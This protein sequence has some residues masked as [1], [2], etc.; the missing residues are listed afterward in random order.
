MSHDASGEPVSPPSA[1]FSRWANRNVAWARIFVEELARAGLRE[2]CIAPGSRSGPLVLALDADPRIRTFVHLDERSAGYFALGIGKA[3]G[4]PAI[5]VTTSGTAAANLLPAVVEASQGEAPL[6]V[7]TADRPHR[8]RG[9]AANQTIDQVK[10]YGPYAR[11]FHDVAPPRLDEECLRYLRGLAGR[12]VAAARGPPA[13]PV[14]LNFPFDKPLEPT[15]VPGDVPQP[16]RVGEAGGA[17]GRPEDRPFT[18][19]ERG[20][21]LPDAEA[22]DRLA[23]LVRAS[24]RGL[25]VCGPAAEPERM[26]PAAL[27]LGAATGYPLLADPLSGAR[28][29]PGAS[30]G[31]LT[32]YDL[33]LRDEEGWSALAP[34][35][36]LRTGLP[37]PSAVLERFLEAYPGATH[38]VVDAGGRWKDPSAV[39]THYLLADPAATFEALGQRLAGMEGGL[40][41]P[42]WAAGWRRA[43]EAARSALAEQWDA[44]FFEGTAVAETAAVLPAGALLFVGNSMPV[45]DLD[46]FA[47][48]RNESLRVLGN[49]GASGIDGTVSTPLGAAA[50]SRGP[51][52]AVIGDLA[53]YHDMNG[54]L[55]ARRFGIDVCFV[56]LNNDGGGIFH[57][58]PIREF[59]P[60]F[61]SHFV[62]PHGLDF[63]H[64]ARL[65][66]LVWERAA[67]RTELRAALGRALAEGGPRIIEVPSDGAQNRRRHEEVAEAVRRAV[68]EARGDGPRHVVGRGW[69]PSA[70]AGGSDREGG[71][72]S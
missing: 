8:L 38:A 28:F 5:V 6:L 16:L 33:F 40:G 57:L 14:H 55:A 64:A 7:L 32:G 37:S 42:G 65:Y 22:L 48:P 15:P 72:G 35:L 23:E 26:G 29:H 53:L 41:D 43:E 21:R 31:A 25:L 39:A 17:A 66:D 1:D 4:R 67:S 70:R 12:A 60:P 2:A 71:R 56:V 52:V 9:Q 36:V 11:L 27:R 34:D 63:R 50:A 68:A 30:E 24:P 45:R 49:R 47:A 20:R 58:L 10:L 44:E 46:A 69:L 51:A 19:V 18:A 61:T 59:E 62:A 54:L 3:T 13:G